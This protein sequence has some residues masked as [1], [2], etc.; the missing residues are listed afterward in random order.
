MEAGRSKAEARESAG[1]PHGVPLA[2]AVLW[3][4]PYGGSI[5]G[6]A[7]TVLL[8]GKDGCASVACPVARAL[9][10][11]N[12]RSCAFKLLGNN[13]LTQNFLRVGPETLTAS[14]KLPSLVFF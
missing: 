13:I 9:E 1:L 6:E 7:V 2:G 14:Q 3:A 11:T 4:V 12:G 8:V 10:A 5:W